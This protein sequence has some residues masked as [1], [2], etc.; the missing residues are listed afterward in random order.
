[1]ENEVENVQQE[2]HALTNTH[3]NGFPH[4]GGKSS[5]WTTTTKHPQRNMIWDQS[6]VWRSSFSNKCLTTE[7]MLE[8]ISEYDALQTFGC[9]FKSKFSPEV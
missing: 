7:L 3:K 4:S 2:V 1:M 6:L 5:L 8:K 9:F